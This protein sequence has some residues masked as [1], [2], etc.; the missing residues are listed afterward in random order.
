MAGDSAAA[1]VETIG[2]SFQKAV[3]SMVRFTSAFTLYG[4]EKAQDA[5]SFRERRGLSNA[6]EDIGVTL[7]SLT[8]SLTNR[9]DETDRGATRSA[10]RIVGQ[11]VEQSLE[12]LSLLDPRRALRFAAGLARTSTEA[13][14]PSSDVTE[15]DE[16][17]LAVDVLTPS[18]D[19]QSQVREK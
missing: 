6:V 10:T 15:E 5:L 3:V 16:P 11:V 12:G 2:N 18:A 4:V 1:V 13:I 19:P 9:M 17:E 7:D 8:E 14:S